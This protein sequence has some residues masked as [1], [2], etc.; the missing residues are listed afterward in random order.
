MTTIFKLKQGDYIHPEKL[1]NIYVQSEWVQQCWMYG[2]PTKEFIVG[3]VV[4]D[5][6]CVKRYQN[7]KNLHIDDK[8][9]M[10]DDLISKVFNSM[11]E[12]ADA[13]NLPPLERPKFIKLLKDP[14]TPENDIMTPTMKIKRNVAIKRY[15]KDIEYLYSLES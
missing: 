14:F 10:K 9:M 4:I 8:L 11:I 5:P 13:N 3:F 2:N 12:V 7:E 15:E 1:E 6:D